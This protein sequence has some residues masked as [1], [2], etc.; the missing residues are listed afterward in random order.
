MSQD[1]PA[2]FPIVVTAVFLVLLITAVVLTVV[3][4]IK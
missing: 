2:R 3:G 4:V 1:G